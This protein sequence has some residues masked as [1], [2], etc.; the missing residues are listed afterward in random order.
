MGSPGYS[1]S[2]QIS[3]PLSR[4]FRSDPLRYS[5]LDVERGEGTQNSFVTLVLSIS[6]A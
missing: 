3:P 1:L 6:F 5:R 4:T 2:R